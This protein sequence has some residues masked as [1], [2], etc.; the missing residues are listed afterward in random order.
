MAK[1]LL[2][3]EELVDTLIVDLNRMI[4]EMANGQFIQVCCIV[5]GMTQ[6]LINLKKGIKDDLENKNKVI[7]QLKDQLKAAGTEIEEMAP[8]EFIEKY[9]KKDGDE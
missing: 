4:K 8:E 6:K 3:N 2:N 7:E 5:N 9:G 1:G